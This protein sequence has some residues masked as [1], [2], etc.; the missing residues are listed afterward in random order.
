MQKQQRQLRSLTRLRWFIMFVTFAC[1]GVS[2]ALNLLHAPQFWVAQAV[3]TIPPVGA[4]GV[5]EL[6]A[7]IPASN[8]WLALGRIAGSV[9]VGGVAAWVSYTSQISYLQAIGFAADHAYMMPAVVDGTMLVTTL[10]L[11]EVVRRRRQLIDQIDDAADAAAEKAKAV[12][13]ET[14]SPVEAIERLPKDA[15]VSPPVGGPQ[16]ATRGTRGEYGPRNGTEYAPST[17]RHK[18]AAAKKAAKA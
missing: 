1:V 12:A 9:V 7:R 4:W 16:M 18:A 14:E 6:I 13:S 5:I 17:K 3:S 10:S 15:P 2:A 8:R 11:V